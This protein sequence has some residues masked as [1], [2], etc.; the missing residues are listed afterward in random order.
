MPTLLVPDAASLDRMVADRRRLG[1]DAKDEVWDGDYVV[2]PDPGN[3]HQ[4]LVGDIRDAL[5]QVV[6]PLG[7]RVFPGCNVSDRDDWRTNYRNPDVAAFLRGNP[8]EDRGSH[9]R[10]GP[11]LAIE[12]VS[13]GDR[14]RDKRDFYAAVGTRE[15]LLIDRS[16]WSLELL[17]LDRGR[18]VSAGVA[19]VGDDSLLAESVGVSWSLATPNGPGRPGVVMTAGDRVWTA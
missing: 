17:R 10:G 19:G 5:N 12:V 8:A 2:M 7:G 11:D 16:P 1:L 9:W 3:E 18:L 4:L 14:S 13:P 6:K 15:L